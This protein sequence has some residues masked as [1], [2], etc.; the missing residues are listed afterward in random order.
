MK[1]DELNKYLKFPIYSI[2]LKPYEKLAKVFKTMPI[3]CN[4][5]GSLTFIR[6]IPDYR[7]T[8]NNFRENCY[9]GHCHSF[10]RQRQLAFVLCN[11]MASKSAKSLKE[12]YK[13]NKYSIYNTEAGGLFH[14]YLSRL[15][16]YQCSEYF[17]DEY[18]SGEMVNGK[19]HQDLMALSFVNERFDIVLSTD[20]FEHISNPYLA[21]KEIYRI[22]KWGGRHIF[23][24]D[25][26]QSTFNDD[27]R[28]SLD[29]DRQVIFYKDALYHIDPLRKNGALVFNVFSIEMLSKLSNLG[30]RTNM[31]HLYVPY[32]GILGS[33]AIVFEAI[34]EK[35]KDEL[36]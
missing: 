21:H 25:F 18:K 36:I 16:D 33:N 17:G 32:N 23:T 22:L 11:A 20:V 8:N 14:D 35:I 31:Y 15:E 28:A 10:N 29:E 6:I 12:F 5:C 26:S 30:F 13:T 9:C 1:I 24:V 2:P 3:R 19:M 4:I 34:K 7:I 27:V